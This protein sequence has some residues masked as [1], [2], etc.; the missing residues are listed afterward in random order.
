MLGRLRRRGSTAR[1]RKESTEVVE[2]VCSDLRP[3]EE[4]IKDVGRYLLTEI[5]TGR[6]R[7]PILPAVATQALALAGN[8]NASFRE[9]Q[10]VIG[11]DAVIT[12]R[13][14][15]AANSAM[16]NTGTQVSSL[17]GALNRLG[18][19]T[20]RDILYQAVAEAHFFE[21]L[22]ASELQKQ[23]THAI[24]VAHTVRIVANLI[25][26]KTEYPFLCGLLH[27]I[28][29]TFLTVNLQG[30]PPSQLH[31]HE[32]PRVVEGFHAIVGEQIVLK[33]DLPPIVA[34]ATRFHHRYRGPR[35]PDGYSQIGNVVAAAQRA[36]VRELGSELTPEDQCFSDLDLN[37]EMLARLEMSVL[38]MRETLV[39]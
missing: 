25:K 30:K 14:I 16:Y 11:G 17:M 26:L 36:L 19:G 9:V 28:G 8:P 37:D 38:K 24:E 39:G 1:K 4:R 6:I 29:R 32:I 3:I 10:R 13:V 31:M 21:G 27:D 23:K 33:W 7:L 12:A 22:D 18:I 20:L 35:V 15:S 34:E 2:H 5:R